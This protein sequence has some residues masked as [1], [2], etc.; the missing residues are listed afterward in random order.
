MLLVGHGS[1]T[2]CALKTPKCKFEHLPFQ[3]RYHKMQTC[4]FKVMFSQLGCQKE[5]ARSTEMAPG[6]DSPSNLYKN[7]AMRSHRTGMSPGEDSLVS[8]AMN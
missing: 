5:K 6:G 2:Q 1:G 4:L 3:K 7:Y 8:L